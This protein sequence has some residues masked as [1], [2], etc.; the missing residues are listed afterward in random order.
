ME[1]E[2]PT[3]VV[4]TPR[5]LPIAVA[6]VAIAIFV[7]DSVTPVETT[8][9]VLYGAVVLMAVRF[10]RP[11]GVVIAAVG[12]TA[13]TVLSH[14]LSPGDPWASTPLINRF[15]GVSAIGATTFLAL[16]NRSAQMALQLAELERVT[17][18]RAMGELTASIAHEIIQPLSAVVTNCNTCL[19]WLEDKTFD[20]AKARS[21]ATRAIRDAERTNDIIRRIRALMTGSETQ[22][23]EMDM[24]GTIREV[25]ALIN[26][27]LLK[28]QVL[29]YTELAAR[30]PPI[31]GDRVQVQQLMLNLI[32]NGVEA[33][34]SVAG[35][36]K[37]LTIETRMDG[38]D[39]VLT[40]V[41]DSGVGLDP[42]KVDQIFNAL[43]TTKPEGT[44]MGLA[45][46]RSI[47][48]AHDGHIWASPA[49]PHGTVFHFTLPAMAI[50]NS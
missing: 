6:A 31:L 22:K 42:E 13:L 39:H 20:L 37:E 12:C 48:E 4:V 23:L 2:S 17:R 33:M 19:H 18:L 43:F 32:M 1:H 38:A 10:F 11:R 15:L 7:F 36:P 50:G 26:D 5:V 47:V 46:C 14:F 29:V 45:I 28:R 40:L 8:A 49:T 21:A 9:G 30:L 24:N 35:R 3:P 44:G 25:L 41:R 16:K 34:A 27:E